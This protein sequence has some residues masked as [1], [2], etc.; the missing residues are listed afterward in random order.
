M[1]LGT[2]RIIPI[3]QITYD[4]GNRGRT[5]YGDIPELQENIR[6]YGL[7]TPI[8]VYS[9]TLQPPFRLL[10]GGRRLLAVIALGWTEISCRIFDK[11]RS[12]QELLAIELFENLRR[13]DLAFYDE[14]AMKY[15]LHQILVNMKGEK[16]KRTADADGHSQADTAKLLGVSAATITQDFKLAHA[17]EAYPDLNIKGIA[18]NKLQAMRMIERFESALKNRQQARKVQSHLKLPKPPPKVAENVETKHISRADIV[19]LIE[20]YHRGD[21]FENEL[22]PSQFSCIEVDPPYGIDIADLRKSGNLESLKHDYIEVADVHYYEFLLRLC[23]KCYKLATDDAWM[24]LWCGPQWYEAAQLALK[25]AGWV[26][27]NIPGIWKKGNSPGQTFSPTTNLG[28]SYEMFIY[29]RKGKAQLRQMGRSNIFD[30]AGL[31]DSKRIH[32]T[33]RP[34]ELIKEILGTFAWPQARI[35]VPFAGSGATLQAA[36]ELGLHAVGFD[37]SRTFQEAFIARVME[38]LKW[39]KAHV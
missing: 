27:N 7:I 22:Q 36:Y 28:N 30:F 37:L 17:L 29:A 31:H 19:A 13:E 15:R 11:E 35:L 3:E 33:E 21:F 6:E 24:I 23:S 8:A 10:G 4:L 18:K 34:R 20:S 25:S 26:A 2:L 9:P 38:E 12:E 32:P 39:E 14:V 1:D 5:F 16:L